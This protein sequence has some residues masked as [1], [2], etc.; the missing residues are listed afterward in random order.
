MRFKPAD[1]NA[2]RLRAVIATG[3]LRAD[4][5]RN[6]VAYPLPAVRSASV[7]MRYLLRIL[8]TLSAK[9]SS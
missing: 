4:G 2:S 1:R 3:P 7:Y 6:G 8:R 5:L 9:L